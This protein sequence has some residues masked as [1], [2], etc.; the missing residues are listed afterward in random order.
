MRVPFALARG[1]MHRMYGFLLPLMEI[2]PAVCICNR[3][4]RTRFENMG[5]DVTTFNA[6]ER[7]PFLAKY[8]LKTAGE[9]PV[10]SLVHSS[11]PVRGTPILSMEQAT[12][13]EG[14][15]ARNNVRLS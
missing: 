12:F 11:F 4:V 14:P 1:A 2:G 8:C 6:L 7:D 5:C 13:Q 9:V 10:P 15:V 3:E